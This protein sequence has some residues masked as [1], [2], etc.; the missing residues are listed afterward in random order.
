LR[1]NALGI[2]IEGPKTSSQLYSRLEIEWIRQFISRNMINPNAAFRQQL[3][4]YM[5]KV[6]SQY[7]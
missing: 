5:K 7:Q 6:F 2:I 4:A 1:L 3:C